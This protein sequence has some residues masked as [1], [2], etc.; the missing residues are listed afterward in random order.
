MNSNSKPNVQP[1]KVNKQTKNNNQSKIQQP[2]QQTKLQQSKPQQSKPQQSPQQ[3]QQSPQQP[4]QSKIQ[5]PNPQQPNPQQLQQQPQQPNPQQPQQSPQQPQQTKVQQTTNTNLPPLPEPIIP[6]VE[7][8]KNTKNTKTTENTKETKVNKIGKSRKQ[9]EVLYEELKI[10]YKDEN[11]FGKTFSKKA[12]HLKCAIDFLTL[13]QFLNRRGK[14][15]D[16]EYSN[17]KKRYLWQYIYYIRI[18]NKN[19]EMFKK[20]LGLGHKIK[21][22]QLYKMIKEETDGN[23]SNKNI[24][25]TELK[26]FI[27]KLFRKNL[28]LNIPFLNYYV[29]NNKKK[30]KTKTKRSKVVDD[31]KKINTIPAEL[32]I[33]VITDK[34]KVVNDYDKSNIGVKLNA[35]IQKKE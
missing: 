13:H 30:Y 12:K 17:I 21:A 25:K 16:N 3:P 34:G 6:L 19:V 10:T 24:K 33:K 26:A 31:S 18:N 29:M 7:V 15:K 35:K 23:K 1:S 9:K 27:N 11:V 4:Q 20:Y 8:K 32:Q 2:P 28:D 22:I 5:K 14:I